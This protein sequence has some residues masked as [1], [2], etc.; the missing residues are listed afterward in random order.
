M[1]G[2]EC[3][4][5]RL[6]NLMRRYI[7]VVSKQREI[8][9]LKDIVSFMLHV[10]QQQT[11]VAAPA[12]R[13]RGFIDVDELSAAHLSE[14]EFIYILTST[15]LGAKRSHIRDKRPALAKF[16]LLVGLGRRII[17]SDPGE[18]EMPP[19]IYDIAT[20]VGKF[21][22][23]CEEQSMYE[24]T[25]M[26]SKF[27]GL[28]VVL[29]AVYFNRRRRNMPVTWRNERT[30]RENDVRCVNALRVLLMEIGNIHDH[31]CVIF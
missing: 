31:E 28:F 4:E 5:L 30:S 13:F 17:Y 1:D 12:G 7:N 15:N 23:H 27:D 9:L 14:S 24:P 26:T 10:E 19:R 11:F 21:V 16:T 20:S 18:M 6:V 22:Y 25:H 3:P 2:P 8:D 29:L